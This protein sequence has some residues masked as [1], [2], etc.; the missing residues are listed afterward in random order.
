MPPMILALASVLLS[1]V[2]QFALK[3]GMKAHAGAAPWLALLQPMVLLGLA[4]Y[5][6]G[7]LVWLAVLAKWDVSK[8]YPLVGIGFALSVVVGYAMC[9][10]FGLARWA[11]VA[12][13]CLGVY[14]ISRT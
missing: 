13:I 1:V 5:G 14:L 7:A 8:A 12:F 11:G 9:E 3:A 4:L 2:A 6:A 10:Q